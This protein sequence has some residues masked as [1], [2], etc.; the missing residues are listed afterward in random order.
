MEIGYKIRRDDTQIVPTFCIYL[1]FCVSQIKYAH[2][3]G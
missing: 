1:L 2:V 3:K